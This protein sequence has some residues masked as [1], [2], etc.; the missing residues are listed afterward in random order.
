MKHAFPQITG[1]L[2]IALSS[3]LCLPSASSSPSPH[4]P[5]YS[6]IDANGILQT[7]SYTADDENGFRVSASNLPQPPRDELQT[8]QETA[9]VAAAKRDHLDELRKSHQAS[10]G[11]QDQ[12]LLSY[13]ILPSYFSFAQVQREVGKEAGN[14]VNARESTEVRAQPTIGKVNEFA[15]GREGG[16]PGFRLSRNRQCRLVRFDLLAERDRTRT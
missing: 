14:G 10:S 9:E 12:D 5:G 6:Y 8:I 16:L 13:K 11:R 2:T 15:R 3:Y 1:A 7:V 4:P